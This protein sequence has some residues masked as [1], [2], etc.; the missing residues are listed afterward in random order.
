MT[1]DEKKNL[2]C[3]TRYI[4]D[5]TA[6]HKQMDD[7]M[8]VWSVPFMQTQGLS[9]YCSVSAFNNLV[10]KEVTTAREMNDVADVLWLRNFEDLQLS[11]TADVQ[12]HRDA[13]GFHSIETMETIAMRHGY[14]I[15]KPEVCI[16]TRHGQL[17]PKTPQELVSELLKCQ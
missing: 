9:H 8:V 1:D 14:C 16:Q 15:S 10:G 6:V 17:V 2:Y 13:N 5:T 7:V 3:N 12:R 4:I 11:V